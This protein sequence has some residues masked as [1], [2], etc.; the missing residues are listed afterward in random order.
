MTLLLS[1]QRVSTPLIIGAKGVFFKN[2]PVRGM[3]KDGKNH[4]PMFI[5][6][7]ELG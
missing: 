1:K 2:C 5:K 7:T 6:L 4:L 3:G